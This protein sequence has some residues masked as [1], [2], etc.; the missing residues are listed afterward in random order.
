MQKL[1]QET[2]DLTA[3]NIDKIAA[4]FPNCV[5][6]GKD[7]SGKLIR[8]IDFDK[9]KQEL[10]FD[11]LDDKQE[12]YDFTWVGKNQA[13]VDANAPIRKTLR[14]C[15]TESRDF[16]NTENLYI[17]GDNLHVLK[18]LQES[19]L[20]KVKMI[21]IDPP[22]NTGKDF[23]YKDNFKQAKEEFEEDSGAFDDEGH[24]Q[25]LQNND[26]NPRFHSDWCSMIYARLR[27]AKN[28]LSD[29]G[30]IFISIDDNE[31]AQLRKICD[32]VFGEVNHLATLVYDKNRKN[33]A[34]Y[35]SI[36]HEYMIAYFKNS[37]FF[38]EMD[39]IFRAPKEGVSE[40]KS[41]FE[42][43]KCQYGSDW[44]K[45]NIELKKLYSS[46]GRD[47]QRAPLARFT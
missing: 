23:I 11:V 33:D 38:Q 45:V 26:T 44:D 40:V 30:V 16:E 13:I 9:L 22:Y 6:E 7:E 36:G 27:L 35:F 2:P 24:R 4:L 19:Y 8:G 37:S 20:G 28:L 29:D 12:R 31:V 3:R 14:P 43:L 34:R 1:P 39:I 15:T 21:C 46:W 10:S 25:F 17:E 32:E 5:T 47:D 41:F 18:L 42:E